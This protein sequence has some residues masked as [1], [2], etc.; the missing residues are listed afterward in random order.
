MSPKDK[1]ELLAQIDLAEKVIDA[2]TD[3][4][5]MLRTRVE[6]I[7]TCDGEGAQ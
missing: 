4:I 1:A 2:L 5:A 6:S 3:M 7:T